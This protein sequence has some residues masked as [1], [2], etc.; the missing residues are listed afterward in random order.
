[1]GSGKLASIRPTPPLKTWC[2][3]WMKMQHAHTRKSRSICNWCYRSNASIWLFSK[4]NGVAVLPWESSDSYAYPVAAA[5]QR[6]HIY[7]NLSNNQHGSKIQPLIHDSDLR[8]KALARAEM[9]K[10]PL[11][12]SRRFRTPGQKSHIDE[13]YPTRHSPSHTWTRPRRVPNCPYRKKRS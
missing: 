6:H 10:Q 1:M 11:P 4:W 7:D 9:S 8:A 5:F 12:P 2:A 13:S 3:E